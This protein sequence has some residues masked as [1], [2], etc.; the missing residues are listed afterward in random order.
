MCRHIRESEQ[1]AHI[2]IVLLTARIELED[3]LAGLNEGADVYLTK[4]FAKQELLAQVKQVLL[5][6]AK[7]EERIR[8]IAGGDAGEA[9]ETS[10]L[11]DPFIRQAEKVI[12]DELANPHFSLEEFARRLHLS[13]SQV[14]RKIKALTGLST[15]L[16]VRSIRLREARTLLRTSQLSVSEIAYRTGFT[17]PAYFSQCFKTTYGESPSVYREG[18]R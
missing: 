17:S 12:L 10:K 5:G 4:P 6:R 8:A 11:T 2:P 7:T 16:F 13:N 15:A 14:Y 3:R 9:A 18:V 1:L